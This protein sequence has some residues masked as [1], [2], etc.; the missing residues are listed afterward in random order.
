MK[1]MHRIVIALFMVLMVLEMSS[2]VAVFAAAGYKDV[3]KK[4]IDTKSIRSIKLIKKAGGFKGVF[5]GKKFRPNSKMTRRQY[6]MV[7]DNLYPGKVTVT[8]N[9]L[10]KANRPVTEKYVT[11]KMV[12]VADKYGMTM[13]WDGGRKKLSRASVCNYIKSFAEFDSAFAID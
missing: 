5:D 4:T 12:K 1:N 6:L 10:K 7:L 13:I 8:M 3:N 2:T 9:D 11:S